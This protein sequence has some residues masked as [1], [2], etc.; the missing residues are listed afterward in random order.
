MR[1]LNV[2]TGVL[3]GVVLALVFNLLARWLAHDAVHEVDCGRPRPW[4]AGLGFMAGLGAFTGPVDGCSAATHHCRRL[5]LAGKDQGIG[6]YFRF[7]TDHKVV[8]VQYL[9]LVMVMLG[10]GGT[11]AMLIRTDLISPELGLPRARRPT[12]RWSGCTG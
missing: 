8:G 1:R 12:T 10:A 5:F 6:R 3:G 4:S 11:M 9:V 7:T 2:G